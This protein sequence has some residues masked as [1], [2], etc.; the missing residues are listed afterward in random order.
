MFDLDAVTEQLAAHSFK[1]TRQ[2]RAVLNVIAEADSRL[3]PAE[4]YD[5]AK[6]VC[7][8]LGLATVYRTMELLDELGAIRRVHTND[9]CESF[10]PAAMPHGH[11]VICVKCNRVMEFE[12]CDISTV[13][14][15]A[16]RQTGFHI[17]EHWLELM[18]TCDT[19][20]RKG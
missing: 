7:P 3:S 19:C 4:V 15:S 2:R 1:L 20:N 13:I 10:A 6:R 17:E 11:H 14:R 9:N 8:D 12:G 18:G 16:A 5:R